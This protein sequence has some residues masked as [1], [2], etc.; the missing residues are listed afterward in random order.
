MWSVLASAWVTSRPWWRSNIRCWYVIGME[1]WKWY[2]QQIRR[3]YLLGKERLRLRMCRQ[4]LGLQ[5]FCGASFWHGSSQGRQGTKPLWEEQ[6]K[7]MKRFDMKKT[8]GL[9]ATAAWAELAMAMAPPAAMAPCV[10]TAMASG[11]QANKGST[12]HS[13][14]RT[15]NENTWNAN[16]ENSWYHQN[17]CLNAKKM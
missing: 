13:K 1:G 2:P 6:W 8:K 10:A 17:Q 3:H 11:T 7:A 4:Y 12:V 16:S 5:P 15:I 14:L 9:M